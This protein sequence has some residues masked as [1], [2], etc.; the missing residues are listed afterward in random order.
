MITPNLANVRVCVCARER[1]REPMEHTHA[2]T[3]S[4]SLQ[5]GSAFHYQC[6]AVF[7]RPSRVHTHTH[8]PANQRSSFA[9]IRT[10]KCD[11]HSRRFGSQNI[12]SNGRLVR[13]EARERNPRTHSPPPSAATRQLV[14]PINIVLH[15][16]I[17]CFP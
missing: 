13:H 15:E 3:L 17:E 14:V 11:I 10:R 6:L 7:A 12:C 5:W 1:E 2:R 9:F 4:V 8:L 16:K